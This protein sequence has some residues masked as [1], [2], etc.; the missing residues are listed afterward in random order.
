MSR[1]AN[2]RPVT[3]QRNT[4]RKTRAH[5]IHEH[6]P[7]GS[8]IARRIAKVILKR[9][10]AIEKRSNPEPETKKPRSVDI[11]YERALVVAKK[12]ASHFERSS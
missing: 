12:H 9:Q 2:H 10:R 11:G 6:N 5:A 1:L 7:S 4:V 3:G 8:K